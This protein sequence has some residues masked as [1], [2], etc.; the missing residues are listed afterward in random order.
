MTPTPRQIT[1]LRSLRYFWYQMAAQLR[2]RIAEAENRVDWDRDTSITRELLRKLLALGY[3]RRHAPHV[4]G[5]ARIQGPPVYVLTIRGSCALATATGE[6]RH[7]LQCEPTFRDYMSL[8]HFCSLATLHATICR[9]VAAQTYVKQTMFCFEHEIINPSAENPS[10]RYRL[11]TSFAANN[12]KCC[13][14]SLIELEVRDY[15]RAIYFEYSTGGDGSPAREIA[16][17]HK[18]YA[19]LNETKSYRRHCPHA[20][21][22]R[23][24]AVCPYAGYRDEMRK[25][26]KQKKDST[27]KLLPGA[28][29]WL[30]VLADDVTESRF[31]HAPIFYTHDGGPFSLVPAPAQAPGTCS[32]AGGPGGGPTGDATASEV[33]K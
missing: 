12:I 29:L 10:E 26:F 28:D 24:I 1:V 2:D 4:P 3:V 15:R 21:D 33:R 9:A 30:F 23:V 27:G 32:G 22:M 6:P 11:H 8:Y 17:K 7:I 13:P 20:R 5:N 14:D 19:Q 31:L 16:M 18:G 25:A